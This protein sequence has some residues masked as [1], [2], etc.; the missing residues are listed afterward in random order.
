MT[1][2]YQR[3]GVAENATNEE[4]DRAW[5]N[6]FAAHHP[7]RYAGSPAKEQ[8]CRELSEAREELKDPARRAALDARL[9]GAPR[10]AVGQSTR[11][12]GSLFWDV[13]GLSVKV[14]AGV[15][16]LILT[17]K[18][19]P[20]PRAPKRRRTRTRAGSRGSSRSSARARSSHTRR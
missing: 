19:R 4:I 8:H 20:A 11:R 10:V 9:R 16:A 2:A 14:A 3:L 12:G 15:A 6:A 17:A 1:N 5:R 7:D 13:L 18:S